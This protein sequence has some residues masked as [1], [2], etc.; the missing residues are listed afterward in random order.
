M[1]ETPAVSDK[2]DFDRADVPA[3]NARMTCVVC[4]Q[5]IETMYYAVNGRHACPACSGKLAE[6]AT[7]SGSFM[8]ATLLGAGVGVVGALVYYGIAALTGMEFGLISIVVG[9][10]VGKAVRR[11]AGLRPRKR[12]RALA[13]VLTYVSITATYIPQIMAAREATSV[14]EAAIF[15]LMVPGFMLMSFENII[16][17][18]ILGIGLYEAWRHS[19]APKVVLEGPFMLQ[20]SAAQPVAA[21]LAAPVEPAL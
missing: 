14:L 2:L 3:E 4:N 19:A 5:A 8:L 12:Y 20:P 6:S 21:A 1:S 15:A 11:G 9:Y 18:F 13:M 10:F 7:G 17:L 16:G